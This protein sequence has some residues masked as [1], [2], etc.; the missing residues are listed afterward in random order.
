MSTASLPLSAD[1]GDE[2]LLATG[3]TNEQHRATE[4]AEGES[5]KERESHR[6]SRSASPGWL[7]AAAVRGAAD[8]GVMRGCAVA[9][10]RTD[11]EHHRRKGVVG[12]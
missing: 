7:S 9:I 4:G 12:R 3:D 2:D 6:E 10:A 1:D 11:R 5:E 8:E